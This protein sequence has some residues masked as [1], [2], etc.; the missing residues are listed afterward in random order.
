M[1]G[2]AELAIA[3][4]LLGVLLNKKEAELVALLKSEGGFVKWALAFGIVA[5]VAGKFGDAGDQ[6]LVMVWIALLMTAVQKNP[7]LFA[8]IAEALQLPAS[9]P[10]TVTN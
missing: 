8:S 7:R 3:V 2:Y 4:F 5:A 10:A 6:F 9:A 1:S